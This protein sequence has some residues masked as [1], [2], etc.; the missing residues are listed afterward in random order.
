M[1]RSS[2]FAGQENSFV[3]RVNTRT[4]YINRINNPNKDQNADTNFLSI[5]ISTSSIFEIKLVT[6]KLF[7][8]T[9]IILLCIILLNSFQFQLV[10][11]FLGYGIKQ[12]IYLLTYTIVLFIAVVVLAFLKGYLLSPLI[13]SKFSFEKILK[14]RNFIIQF[15]IVI[16]TL[17]RSPLGIAVNF[18]TVL[19]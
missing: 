2:Y 14:Y 9:A 7:S 18:L 15:N 19:N 11:Q 3:H 16:I 17:Y 12:I 13:Q 6:L 5:L 8:E 1:R 4:D 10:F